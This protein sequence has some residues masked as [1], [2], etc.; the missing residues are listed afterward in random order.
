[1]ILCSKSNKKETSRLIRHD[2]MQMASLRGYY[3]DDYNVFKEGGE[4]WNE[5]RIRTK[6]SWIRRGRKKK[7]W[8][9]HIMLVAHLF[10]W[11]TTHQSYHK[12]GLSR[13]WLSFP[14]FIIRGICCLFSTVLVLSSW[15]VLLI[16]HTCSEVLLAD[17][18]CL[19][20]LVAIVSGSKCPWLSLFDPQWGQPISSLVT[21]WYCRDGEE[22]TPPQTQTRTWTINSTS[23]GSCN[24]QFFWLLGGKGVGCQ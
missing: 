9:V 2:V 20:C 7:S 14:L 21:T 10:V 11:A 1:M 19:M 13:K 5:E 3:K 8:Q 12:P 15:L 17:G 24:Y 23:A 18:S 22:I 16:F 6:R 4:R